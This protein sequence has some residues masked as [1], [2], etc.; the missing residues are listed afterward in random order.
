MNTVRIGKRVIGEGNPCF[1]IAEIGVNHNGDLQLAKKMISAAVKSGADAVKFQTWITDETIVKDIPKPFY[2]TV[3]TGSEE[4]QYEMAKKLELNEKDFSALA[5]F[6]VAHDIDFLS[7]PEG[8]TCTDWLDRIGVRAYKISSPDLVNHPDLAYIAQKKKPVI[9]STGMATLNEI[10]DAVRIIRTHGNPDIIL[11]HCTSCYPT[12]PGDVNLRALLTLK[13]RFKIPVGFSDHTT[14]TFAAGIAVAL[15]ACIIEKHFTLD[16]NLPGPD[17][18]ASL[19]PREFRTMVDTIRLTEKYLGSPVKMP[20]PAEQE[21]IRLSRKYLVAGYNIKKGRVI[22]RDDIAIKKTNNG[23][24]FPTFNNIN[25]LV[26]TKARKNH[27]IDD[28][29]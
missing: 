7:T 12:N 17:H 2:Q 22:H 24:H 4:S 23:I 18:Q 11:L 29:L 26:G 19:E 16:R 14:G 9:L 13:K 3:T 25:S 6:A 15:G 8:I 1:I 10:R 5:K 21:M 27:L 28:P 20:V